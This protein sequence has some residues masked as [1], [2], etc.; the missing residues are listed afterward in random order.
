MN[1]YQ[2]K[3]QSKAAYGE[4]SPNQADPLEPNTLIFEDAQE[5]KGFTSVPNHILRNPSISATAKATYTLL[6]SY[7]WHEGNC[8]P[9]QQRLAKD[10]GLS[11]RHI[12]RY[13]TELMKCDLIKVIRRGLGK[14]NI[15]II[16]KMFN[17]DGTSMSHQEKTSRS[18]QDRTSVSYKE[19]SVEEDPVE[20][21]SDTSKFRKGIS[22]E[23]NRNNRRKERGLNDESIPLPK[24][25]KLMQK[26]AFSLKIGHV[27]YALSKHDLHDPTHINSNITRAMNLWRRS[28]L[29][30]EEFLG[31][32]RD[33]KQTTFK[34][35]G[36]IRKKAGYLG[37]KNLA[38][39]FFQVLTDLIQQMILATFRRNFAVGKSIE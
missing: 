36:S 38:P 32:I 6:L 25:Q 35:S 21:Y 27:F 24:R 39:Y 4:V 18:D 20:K 33:A 26:D 13:L 17:T 9:V 8:F 3:T 1:K 28:K 11:V 31:L 23:K 5:A 7:A 15:Y 12:R 14:T 30:E 37:L 19:Y 34:H 16:R 2:L 10:F 29:S 22:L